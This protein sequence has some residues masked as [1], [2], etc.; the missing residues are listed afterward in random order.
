MGRRQVGEGDTAATAGGDDRPARRCEGRV[1]QPDVDARPSFGHGQG[2]HVVQRGDDALVVQEAQGHL[3][4]VARRAHESRQFLA[5]DG[6][7]GQGLFDDRA[8]D[9]PVSYT[10]LTLPT[11]DL[12]V[13]SVDAGSIKKK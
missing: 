5:I 10:P 1:A 4:Q 9:G 12:G 7:A 13:N 6:D 2:A 11:T 3:W 8:I